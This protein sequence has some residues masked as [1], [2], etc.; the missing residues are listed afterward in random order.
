[1]KIKKTQ[2]NHL[3]YNRNIMAFTIYIVFKHCHRIKTP[4]QFRNM[5]TSKT[6]PMVQNIIILI[7]KTQAAAKLVWKHKFYQIR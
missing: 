6:I 4:S 5:N 7:L 1:M 3:I 2:K